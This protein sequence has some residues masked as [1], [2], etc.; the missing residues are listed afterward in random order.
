MS[1][2]QI[3]FGGN[4]RLIAFGD[5]KLPEFPY[6]VP[7][8]SWA[9]VAA[10]MPAKYE[11]GS[12]FYTRKPDPKLQKIQVVDYVWQTSGTDIQGLEAEAEVLYW[13]N[14][15]LASLL[16]MY[17]EHTTEKIQADVLTFYSDNP[18]YLPNTVPR[19]VVCRLSRPADLA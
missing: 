4:T 14:I 3:A 18:E 17:N 13:I 1:F 9:T 15:E 5:F 16:R 6:K 11:R 8:D 7:Y 12:F 10:M 2:I 19:V